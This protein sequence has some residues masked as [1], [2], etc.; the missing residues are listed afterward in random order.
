[1]YDAEPR[2][3]LLLVEDDAFIQRLI[4]HILQDCYALTL[5]PTLEAARE[6]AARERFDLILIDINLRH[7]TSGLELLHTLRQMP[8]YAKAPILT[9]T[10]FVEPHHRALFRAAGFDAQIDKP[11]TREALLSAIDDALAAH[12]VA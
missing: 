3:R 10:A 7:R 5:A 1:M 4:E 2:A 8:A 12:A 11:F 6:T 9:C